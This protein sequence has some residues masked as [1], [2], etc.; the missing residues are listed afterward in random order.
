[1]CWL[2]CDDVKTQAHLDSGNLVSVARLLVYMCPPTSMCTGAFALV[3]W[4]GEG[5]PWAVIGETG[6][7]LRDILDRLRPSCWTQVNR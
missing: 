4:A 1:M 3:S 6:E 7:W 2:K 5:M